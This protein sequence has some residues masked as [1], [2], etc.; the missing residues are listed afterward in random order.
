MKSNG[1]PLDFI[2][3][4]PLNGTVEVTE[5][6]MMPLINK[7][8]ALYNKMSRRN[9]LLYGAATYT[10]VIVA[11]M[12]DEQFD[13]IVAGG[14]G[15]WIKL[16]PDSTAT[17]LETPTSALQDMEKAI[18]SGIEEMAK[19]G[20]RM[21]SPETAQSG[22][23]LELRNASQNAQ[24]GSLNGKV[25]D[26][27]SQIVAFMLNWRYDTDYKAADVK[28]TLSEDFDKTPLG[29]DWLR[30]ATEWYEGGKVP[31]SVWLHLLRKNELLPPDYDDEEGQKEITEDQDLLM[32]KQEREMEY[33]AE[34]TAE[35]AAVTTPVKK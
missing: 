28:F 25:S 32:A 10:P 19:L 26:T 22:V 31:R 20:I 17:V 12:T 23:A 24:L 33:A 21:L 30:L 35:T 18:A 11:D 2:P 9:H 27:M 16:P 14:L 3:A 5:P 6:I 29:A 7:E 1:E 13:A 4:W 15:T 8:L 34:L